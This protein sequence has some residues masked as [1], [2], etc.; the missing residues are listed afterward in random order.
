VVAFNEALERSEP[1]CSDGVRIDT[2]P[3][4][5]KEIAI[6]N[7]KMKQGLIKDSAG[8]V[9]VVRTDGHIFPIENPTSGCR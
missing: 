6:D 7:L 5:I 1:I 4:Y 8:G 9:W 2:T 3:P